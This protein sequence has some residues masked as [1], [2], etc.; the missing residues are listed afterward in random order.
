MLQCI[1]QLMMA[2]S[3]QINKHW[4]S[5]IVGVKIADIIN[6]ILRCQKLGDRATAQNHFWPAV[7]FGVWLQFLCI[8]GTRMS[9]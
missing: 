2:N 5:E 7:P 3:T 9:A 1:E 8:F 4:I 6:V